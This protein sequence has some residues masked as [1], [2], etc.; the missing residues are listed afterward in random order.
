M[1]NYTLQPV[2]LQWERGTVTRGAKAEGCP[3]GNELFSLKLLAVREITAEFH[4]IQE[5]P[6]RRVYPWAHSN[7]WE[8]Q[9]GLS[10]LPCKFISCCSSPKAHRASN[11]IPFNQ[12]LKGPRATLKSHKWASQEGI[13]QS[14]SEMFSCFWHPTQNWNLLYTGWSSSSNTQMENLCSKWPQLWHVR[15]DAS[16]TYSFLLTKL[17]NN[18]PACVL[19]SDSDTLP[20]GS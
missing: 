18:F 3:H 14:Y 15:W 9:V 11:Q 1:R 17:D 16:S 2:C 19:Q 8:A 6:W 7:A 4:E 20:L 10:Q 12:T 5:L 13:L